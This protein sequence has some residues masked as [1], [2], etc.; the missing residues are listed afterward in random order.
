VITI[1]LLRKALGCL[2]WQAVLLCSAFAQSYQVQIKTAQVSV[3]IEGQAEQAIKSTQMLPWKWDSHYLKQRGIARFSLDF[4]LDAPQYAA[5]RLHSKGLGMTALSM[6]NRYR[7]QINQ[8]G[9]QYVGWEQPTTQ[10]RSKPKWH[11]LPADLLMIGLNT[12]E[13]EIKMEPANDAG[14]SVIEVSD[15]ALSM[16]AIQSE[17]ELRHNSMVLV[18]SFSFLLSLFA[19]GMWI[20]T[21]EELFLWAFLADLFFAARQSSGF[22]DYPP[23]PTWAWN[24]GVTS[25]FA[26]F[27]G[28]TFKTAEL[29]V[30]KPQA[31]VHKL[32]VIYLC[33][34]AP[35]L[36][37]G[38]A[39]GDIRF[40]RTW[41]LVMSMGTLVMVARVTWFALRTRDLNLRLYAA[42]A[43]MAMVLGWY[44]FIFIQLSDTGLGKMRLGSYT[45]ILFN[46]ALASI[47][48]RKYIR[49]KQEA[50]ESNAKIELEATRAT[51]TERQRLMADIHDTVGAQLV[52]VLDLIR[53][54][55]PHEQLEIETADALEDLRIAIDAIQPVNGSLTV[56]L[57]T[58]RHRLEPRLSAT[59][60]Q[61]LWHVEALPRLANLTPQ[62]IQHIQRIVLEA[63]SNVMKH[64]KARTI[65]FTAQS[66]YEGKT[67]VIQI[68][69]DGLGFD[70]AALTSTGQGLRTMRFRAEAVGA[71]L[72]F[73]K[74]EP[75]G[76]RLTL[77]L[78][79]V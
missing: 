15:A 38:N 48:V 4:R 76:T 31:L 7:Y 6:G 14:L 33:L 1:P 9:W 75:Y 61:L 78:P 8:S 40:Y 73:S 45:T 59:G 47:I 58:L 44:D 18:S 69:D 27:V 57:A 37:L 20:A 24:A 23:I 52:G 46:L 50:Y 12:I 17:V 71:V 2:A 77:T 11:S 64:A 60:I 29:L 39:L 53:T 41:L 63:I 43:W 19:F 5:A 25:L 10:Y 66:L 67:V 51:L 30:P 22:I 21:K 79:I 26:L 16:A 36:I 68:T 72:T 49:A 32:I 34:S 62:M 54:K 55:A 42:A 65:T 56:V 28:F 35:L 3:T 74:A 13:L 70:E